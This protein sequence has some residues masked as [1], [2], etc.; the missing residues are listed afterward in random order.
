MIMLPLFF[1][2]KDTNKIKKW[3]IFPNGLLIVLDQ[4]KIHMKILQIFWK[5]LQQ[6]SIK[7]YQKTIKVQPKTTKVKTK[8]IFVKDCL[9]FQL[10]PKRIVKKW[11]SSL[12]AELRKFHLWKKSKSKRINNW[13]T[14]T[15][16]NNWP[17]FLW[18]HWQNPHQC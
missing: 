12:I 14:V 9:S 6:F 2:I 15:W 3:S 10:L 18:I 11:N 1:S 5:M 4:P 8:E 16:T 7:I 13:H 17:T